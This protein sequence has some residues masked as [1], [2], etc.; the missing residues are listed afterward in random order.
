MKEKV[1]ELCKLYQGQS[2]RTYSFEAPSV[3]A[4]FNQ[5]YNFEVLLP[6]RYFLVVPNHCDDCQ[7][8]PSCKLSKL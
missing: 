1:G 2:F 4:T 5:E 8:F 7:Q 6:Q 3:N